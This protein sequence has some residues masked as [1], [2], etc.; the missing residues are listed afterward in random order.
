MDVLEARKQL[1]WKK[2]SEGELPV[3]EVKQTFEGR[4]QEV[5]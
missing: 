5:R 3:A 2:V 1:I 4:T